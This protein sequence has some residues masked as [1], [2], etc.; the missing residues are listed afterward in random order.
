MIITIN[1][2]DLICMIIGTILL[3]LLIIIK[4]KGW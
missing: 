1:L 2:L 3:I 4:M